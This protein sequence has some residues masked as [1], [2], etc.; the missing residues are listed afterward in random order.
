MFREQLIHTVRCDVRYGFIIT[1]NNFLYCGRSDEAKRTVM[2]EKTEHLK[3]YVK[4]DTEIS[5]TVPV[6]S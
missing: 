3:E 4:W 2:S 6:V 5:D 1:K